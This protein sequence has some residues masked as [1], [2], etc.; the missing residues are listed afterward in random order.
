MKIACMIAVSLFAAAA[1]A[2][3][4]VQ[5]GPGPN[6]GGQVEGITNKKVVGA[7]RAVVPHP[8]DADTLWIGSVN[9][10]IWKTTNATASEPAWV[11]QLGLD[12]SLSIGSLALDPTDETH[13]TLL[14][15]SGITSAFEGVGGAQVG[16]WH[17][18]DGGANWKVLDGGGTI[19]K[20]NILGVA[21]RGATMVI[22]AQ[23]YG[24]WRS[25]D[26][27]A[28]WTKI[29]GATGSGLPDGTSYDL[30]SDPVNPERLFTNAGAQGIYRSTDTGATWQKVSD[31]AID[32]SLTG[33]LRNVRV[34]AG[35]SNEV[36]V[37]VVINGQLFALFRSGDGGSTWTALDLPA[38][39]ENGV[40]IGIH[41]GY[42][43]KIDMSIA[44]HPQN[45]NLVFLGGDRQPFRD[46]G[47]TNTCSP[48]FPNSIGATD[49]TGRLFRVDATQPRGKQST[50]IT[51]NY[52]KSNSSPHADSRNLAFDA[53]GDL[54]DVDD[55]G[56]YRRTAPLTNTGDW[57]SVIGDLKTTELHSIAY[58][59]N[60]NLAFGGAQDNGSPE[61]NVPEG[62]MWSALN[63][64]DGGVV[65]ISGTATPGVS[66]RYSSVSF[67]GLFRRG[68]YDSTGKET[69]Y[70]YPPL[71]V[72][73]GGAALQNQFYTPIRV[74]AVDPARLVIG[75]ANGIYE[76]LD[77][78]DTIRSIATIAVNQ[79][80]S[81]PLAYGA[82][83]NPDVLYAGVGTGVYV[84]TARTPAAPVQSTTYPGKLKVLD[85]AIHPLG[86]QTAFV[87][88]EVSVYVTGDAGATWTD[89]TRNLGSL[90]PGKL[91]S[92]TYSTS[93]KNGGAIVGTDSGVYIGANMAASPTEDWRR[94]G[95]GLPSAPVFDL[96]YDAQ[97]QVLAAALMGRGAW[98][99]FLGPA[100]N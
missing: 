56:I 48:C 26:T 99:I 93:E 6:T 17:T 54:L 29:S 37:A 52:T 60:S 43:G 2:Q 58:D 85:I 8:S 31:A 53:N 86:P 81:N 98:T 71:T 92:V 57:F 18:T 62:A 76:S 14:A 80:V 61:Q 51:N 96:A 66:I 40:A 73:G 39:T 97:D 49:Y 94:L 4:W 68:I 72:V 25:T 7:I 63:T 5:Q 22:A 95:S 3:T 15:G 9:G 46:E 75:G 67:L 65:A 100:E 83:G 38:T 82:K 30:A 77:Q 64:G 27:G 45:A 84:R 79:S 87:V 55:G 20:M 35:R 69:S 89:V 78:G 74:N 41:P 44:P 23:D 12:R 34:A 88:D 47:S 70:K 91:R 21:P 50:P 32:T 24:I 11:E 16:V 59:P 42:Q 10:G 1:Q 90:N 13:G 28:T 36:Y 19:A 33:K